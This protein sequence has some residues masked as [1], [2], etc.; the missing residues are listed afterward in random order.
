MDDKKA[1]FLS[2]IQGKEKVSSF[3]ELLDIKRRKLS[4]SVT[5]REKQAARD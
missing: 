1:L 3:R 5:K 4:E 2:I